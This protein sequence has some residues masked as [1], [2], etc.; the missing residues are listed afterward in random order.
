MDAD[1]SR[2]DWGAEYKLLVIVSFLID[3]EE[4]G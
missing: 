4:S 1:Q 3:V 2:E